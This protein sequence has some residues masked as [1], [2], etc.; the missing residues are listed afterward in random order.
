MEEPT[1]LDRENPDFPPSL[2]SHGQKIGSSRV[3]LGLPTIFDWPWAEIW[4]ELGFTRN[5]FGSSRLRVCDIA[6]M[7]R[8]M[9]RQH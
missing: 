4:V 8:A 2:I 6:S 3:L 5:A 9:W 7:K 1:E